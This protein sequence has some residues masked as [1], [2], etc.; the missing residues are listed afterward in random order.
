MQCNYC[1]RNSAIEVLKEIPHL[2][3][4]LGYPKVYLCKNCYDLSCK[5]CAQLCSDD[6]DVHTKLG[7]YICNECY[8]DDM[9]FCVVTYCTNFRIRPGSVCLLH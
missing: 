8:M 7:K 5:R 9:D 1:K 2:S 3:K 4:G 6:L